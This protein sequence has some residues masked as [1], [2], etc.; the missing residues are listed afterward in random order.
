MRHALVAAMG[1]WAEWAAYIKVG[2]VLLRR[3]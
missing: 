1:D 3:R 2:Q